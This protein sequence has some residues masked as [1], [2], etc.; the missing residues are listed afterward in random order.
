MPATTAYGMGH[1]GYRGPGFWHVANRSSGQ[2][3][4]DA[5]SLSRAIFVAGGAG[6]E[7]LNPYTWR[8]CY[9]W[10]HALISA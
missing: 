1:A 6:V 4:V 9:I 2:A 5:P 8:C 3:A 10:T 7:Q